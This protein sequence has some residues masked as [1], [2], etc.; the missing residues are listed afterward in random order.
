MTE[1]A[2]A[3]E[4]RPSPP[5]PGAVPGAHI[6]LQVGDTLGAGRWWCRTLGFE[7]V[8]N[9]DGPHA[10]RSHLL[11]R[12]PGSGLVV[13][14][15]RGSPAAGRPH[16]LSLRVESEQALRDWAA[17]LR[18]RGIPHSPPKDNGLEQRVSLT[19]PDDVR[20][21]LWWPR[22]P[23]AEPAARRRAARL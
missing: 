9:R 16:H 6:S 14:L 11:L 8:E 1:A 20:I 17:H 10:S 3:E 21:E 13:R 23:H 2:V 18:R 7:L 5:G 22:P 15:R 19:G 4:A 12:H